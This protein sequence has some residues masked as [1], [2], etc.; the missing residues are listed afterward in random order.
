MHTNNVA[1]TNAYLAHN[2]SPVVTL[3]DLRTATLNARIRTGRT[4]LAVSVKGGLYQVQSVTYP[5]RKS[6][7]VVPLSDWLSLSDAVNYLEAL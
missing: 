2:S 7:K 6:S 5:T 3:A 1:D 4:D